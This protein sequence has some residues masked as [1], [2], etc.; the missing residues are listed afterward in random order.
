M[1]GITD[2]TTVTG[3]YAGLSMFTWACQIAAVVVGLRVGRK[4]ILLV[5]WP[6]LLASLIAMCVATAIFEKREAA[7]YLATGIDNKAAVACV[8][9]VWI[10]LGIFN[11]SNPV[12]WSYPS[13][14]QTFSMRSKGMLV[15]NTASQLFSGY[16]TFVD[17]VALRSIGWKYYIVYMPLIVLQFGLMWKYMVET[18]GYTLEEIATAFDG[19]H[20]DLTALDPYE[21]GLHAQQLVD[22]STKGRDIEEEP[23]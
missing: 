3:I 23:K 14:I 4:T 13:E 1:V 12:L 11:A 7:G 2:P 9:F 22:S 21:P 8:A 17:S 20:T 6:C 19:S 5:V 15:W 10:Y 16:T 18:K